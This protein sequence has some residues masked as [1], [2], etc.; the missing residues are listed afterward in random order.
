MVRSVGFGKVG[1]VGMHANKTLVILAKKA[2]VA[3][4][5]LA[6]LAMEA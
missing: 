2:K 6:M 1:I 4:L 5:V 3:P